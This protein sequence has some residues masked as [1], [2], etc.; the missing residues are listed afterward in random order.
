MKDFARKIIPSEMKNMHMNVEEFISLYNKK[1]CILLDI[2]VPFET[3]LWQ[4]NFALKIPANEL[5]DRLD[6][7][8]K[9]KLIVTACPRNN[10]SN[11]AM[12]YLRSEGFNVKYLEDGLLKLLEHLRGNKAKDIL[13]H[14]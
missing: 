7:L 10:R 5:P 2:R 9:D 3:D 1:E 8:P 14:P 12:V 6:E 11:M 4:V 13:S